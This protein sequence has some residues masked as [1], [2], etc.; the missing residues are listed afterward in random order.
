MSDR[1]SSL[2]ADEKAQRRNSITDVKKLLADTEANPKATVRFGKQLTKHFDQVAMPEW[3][4][5]Q[6]KVRLCCGRRRAG[7]AA[8]LAADAARPWRSLSAFWFVC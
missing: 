8:R 1:M 5:M 3:Q 6:Y 4:T 2:G 7:G